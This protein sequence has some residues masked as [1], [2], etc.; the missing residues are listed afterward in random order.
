MITQLFRSFIAR[1]FSKRVVKDHLVDDKVKKM[2]LGRDKKENTSQTESEAEDFDEYRQKSLHKIK[3]PIKLH[4]KKMNKDPD[5]KKD[6]DYWQM[7]R[8]Y[9]STIKK[10]FESENLKID[11]LNYSS[12]NKTK[13]LVRALKVNNTFDFVR[14]KNVDAI[15][16]EYNNYS[17]FHQNY[18]YYKNNEKNAMIDPGS[19]NISNN[20]ENYVHSLTP[21]G[22]YDETTASYIR[23]AEMNKKSVAAEMYQ[24]AQEEI[25]EF[26]QKAAKDTNEIYDDNEKV[27]GR[28]SPHA[29]ETIYN[30]Y[31]DG[32]TINDISFKFGILPERAKAIVW[33][34]RYFYDEVVSNI[35]RTMWRLGIEKEIMYAVRFPFV[36]YGVDLS[37]MALFEKGISNIK[38]NSSPIDI[39]PPPEIIKLVHEKASKLK[40]P[41]FYTITRG[42]IGVGTKAYQL[43][44]MVGNGKLPLTEMFKKICF[45]A[46]LPHL[47]P[48]KVRENLNKGPRIASLGFRTKYKQRKSLKFYNKE[49]YS[50]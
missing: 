6:E 43:K 15:T 5:D 1:Q 22:D 3:E 13:R 27:M 17:K 28:L 2:L 20:L 46:D 48:K 14:E 30:L 38:F 50:A 42:T 31:R 16:N 25:D 33:C 35:D 7:Y 41:K 32:W 45:K 12:I 39:D 49:F 9:T 40:P 19:F 26:S 37:V 47:F 18:S 29:T 24:R 36:D 23:V 11:P 21:L 34:K 8:E 10:Y 44:D 4:Q